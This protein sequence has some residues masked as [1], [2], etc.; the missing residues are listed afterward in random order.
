MEIREK[1]ETDGRDRDEE[2]DGEGEGPVYLRN[3]L[4][5][6]GCGQVGNPQEQPA[7]WRHLVRAHVVALP[8][9]AGH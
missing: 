7:G 5:G 4:P 2:V 6:R 9:E 3:W 1:A 8:P